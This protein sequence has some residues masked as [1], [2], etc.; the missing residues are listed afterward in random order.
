MGVGLGSLDRDELALSLAQ[1]VEAQVNG[2]L[3]GAR[4]ALSERAFHLGAEDILA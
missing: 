4:A 3:P 1:A 2:Q